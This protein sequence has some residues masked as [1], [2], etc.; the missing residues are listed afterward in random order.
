MTSLSSRVSSELDCAIARYATALSEFEQAEPQP[1]LQ[2]A[3]NILLARDAI[4][5]AMNSQIQASEANLE[6]LFE[7]DE[8][9][10]KQS[11]AIASVAKLEEWRASINP[12][13][14]SWWWFFQC[15]QKVDSWDRYDGVWNTLSIVCLTAFV[16]YMTDL[17]PR[18]AI[19]GFGVLES[20][21]IFA[22][23]GVMA[24]AFSS[25]QGGAGQKAVQNAL[26]KL[27]IPSRL[28][29]ELTF[30]MSAL[31]LVGAIATQ[32]YLKDIANYYYQL[33]LKEYK[34]GNLREAEDEYKQAL[35]LDPSNSNFNV[36]L[37]EV[38]ESL[39]ELDEAKKQYKEPL[40][41]G[42]PKTFNNLG[43]V[44]LQKGDPVTAEAMFRIGLE[45]AKDDKKKFQLLRNL[46]WVLLQQKQYD[47]AIP[48][49]QDAIEL[50]R[51]ISVK[52][53][54]GGMANCFLA[55]TFEIQGNGDKAAQEWKNCQENARPETI[56]E[57]KWLVQVGKGELASKVDTSAI[58]AE[59]EILEKG[60][61]PEEVN[62]TG[63]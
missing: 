43:R 54:G 60:H 8:R 22:P 24:L 61:I 63:N 42:D 11:D 27:G 62:K 25:L 39:G 29:S 7:L 10:K 45:R 38:Y 37:G 55:K 26:K 58:V 31:L 1:S 40:K 15:P 34:A 59:H 6:T 57:Y 50:E 44:H 32:A 20:F 41:D 33:G 49:L 12:L 48:K 21:G 28:Q 5:S 46:G 2:Q 19:G 56:N 18:F 13:S 51:R 23:G 53:V 36:A 30:G 47:K 17:V 35:S 14:S 52:Q 16:A 4:A 9:L 3:L